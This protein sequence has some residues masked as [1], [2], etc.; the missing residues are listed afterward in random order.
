MKKYTH[1]E[2]R[3][4]IYHWT[5]FIYFIM[6]IVFISASVYIV[7]NEIFEFPFKLHEATFLLGIAVGLWLFFATILF[8]LVEYDKEEVKV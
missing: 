1:E 2:L 8:C 7:S 3:K 6:T 4:I 5:K